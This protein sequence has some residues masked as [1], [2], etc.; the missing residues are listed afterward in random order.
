MFFV[1]FLYTFNNIEQ[2]IIMNKMLTHY[3]TYRYG[4]L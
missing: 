2:D 1:Q 3:E 4:N